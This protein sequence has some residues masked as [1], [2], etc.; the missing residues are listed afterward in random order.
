[1]ISAETQ[2][3]LTNIE[4]S[5]REYLTS[6]LESS[7]DGPWLSSF[8]KDASKFPDGD[9]TY[10]LPEETDPYPNMVTRPHYLTQGLLSYG[11][12]DNKF[13]IRLHELNKKGYS[14]LTLKW[15]ED[16]DLVR[17][18]SGSFC[19]HPQQCRLFNYLRVNGFQ[20]MW[21]QYWFD[22]IYQSVVADS[23]V[24]LAAAGQM[25]WEIDEDMESD[26]DDWVKYCI[27]E[28]KNYMSSLDKD[29]HKTIVD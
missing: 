17:E 14:L 3:E 6:V 15:E 26:L 25:K 16:D 29:P 23:P 4:T 8:F 9:F 28:I 21:I 19:S 18:T 10:E 20:E 22:M 27:E 12:K 24:D 1:M 2:L 11:R 5:W 7:K 13:W